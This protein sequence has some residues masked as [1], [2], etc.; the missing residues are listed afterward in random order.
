MNPNDLFCL[1]GKNFTVDWDVDDV[2]SKINRYV[3]NENAYSLG[4]AHEPVN[5]IDFPC[6][7]QYPNGVVVSHNFYD[8]FPDECINVCDKLSM[9]KNNLK[10]FNLKSVLFDQFLETKSFRPK[11]VR[12]M[13]CNHFIKPHTDLR[14]IGINIGLKNSSN[15]ITSVSES[16]NQNNVNSIPFYQ[17]RLD[18]G[19]VLI[20]NTHHAHWI[21]PIDI[22]IKRYIISYNLKTET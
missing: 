3:S 1:I 5:N 2:I 12:L 15:A 22:N 10:D 20:L 8:F 6:Y 21:E 14:E 9:L 11:R 17:Y 18:D 13:E 19:D 4:I 16:K 7:Q